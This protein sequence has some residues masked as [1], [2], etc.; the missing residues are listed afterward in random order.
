M[1][2]D[3]DVEAFIAKSTDNFDGW[4]TFAGIERPNLFMLLRMQ[5]TYI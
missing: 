1:T 3:A 2:S 5:I 4:D